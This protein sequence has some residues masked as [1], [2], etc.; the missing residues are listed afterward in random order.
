MKVGDINPTLVKTTLLVVGFK[1]LTKKELDR[2]SPTAKGLFHFI[3]SYITLKTVLL[4]TCSMT[5]Y[6]K[7]K[8]TPVICFNYTFTRTYSDHKTTGRLCFM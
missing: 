1:N 2:L 4:F 3:E 6:R 7:L 5:S 8:L